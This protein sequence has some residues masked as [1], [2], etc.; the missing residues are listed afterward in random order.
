VPGAGA[1]LLHSRPRVL[2][3]C[4]VFSLFW[5]LCLVGGQSVNGGW[6]L[7]SSVQ[8]CFYFIFFLVC[9]APIKTR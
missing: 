5:R 6:S 4:A 3:F 9:F 2:D 1:S 8:I 7:E